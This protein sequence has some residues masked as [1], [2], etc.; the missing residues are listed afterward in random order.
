[1]NLATNTGIETHNYV[2]VVGIR[3]RPAG[4]I[5][6][7]DPQGQTFNNGQ[8]VIVETVRGIEAARVVIASK[9]IPESDLTE[10]LKPVQRLA[11]EDELRMMLSF[12]SKE[13]EAMVRCA[14]RIAQ[15]RLPMKLVEA[16]YTF[17]GSRLTFYFTADER[18]DF[19]GLVRD[20]AATFRTRIELRQIG[21]RDQAKLQGG[22]G[23]CGKTLCCSSWIT[24]FGIVSIKMAKEQ[25]LPLNPTKISGVCGRLM[26]CL[27]YENDNYIQAKQQMPQI[28]TMLDTPSG[29]GKVVSVNVPKNSV[30]VMLESGVTIQVPVDEQSSSQ[31]SCACGK[32]SCTCGG[33][34]CCSAKG[35]GG[36]CG[37]CGI[38]KK[39]QKA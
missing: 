22:I 3:F 8:Y 38:K 28:G 19:R 21:A 26:C 29:P 18:V 1:M 4:R 11:T 6:Y 33:G 5:Y 9:K 20:L 24:D 16:E 27:A 15:H 14:E 32:S 37:T 35:G 13:K 12:K 25:G 17:D 39:M 36:G 2:V 31:K 34:G 23:P 30:E 7:F 10:P